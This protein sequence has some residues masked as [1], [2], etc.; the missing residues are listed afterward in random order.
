M[1]NNNDI[2]VTIQN[3]INSDG[4]WY[5][6]IS[7]YYSGCDKATI[8]EGCHNKE[9]KIFG[10]GYKTNAANLII[11]IDVMLNA[12]MDVYKEMAICFVG[13]EPL[14]EYNRE[15]V[16]VISKYFKEKYKNV[17]TI[18]YT[19]RTLE[20]IDCLSEYV[21]D[22]DYGVLGEFIEKEKDI[23]YIPSSKNQYIYDFKNNCKI[24]AVMKG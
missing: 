3:S 1:Q 7:I 14:A 11:D 23:R 4:I 22:I 12:W 9:L 17:H 6:A 2:Y 16:K 20:D 15:S 24:D 19:W 13:G 5:P 21:K 8:C 10:N 18:I